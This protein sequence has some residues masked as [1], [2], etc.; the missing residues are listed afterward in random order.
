MQNRNPTPF[1]AEGWYAVALTNSIRK[2]CRPLKISISGYNFA[3]WRSDAG[4]VVVNE[5]YCP[6]MGVAL[7]SGTIENDLIVCPYHGFAFD[8]T[9][10]CK[11]VPPNNPNDHLSRNCRLKLLSVREEYGLVWVYLSSSGTNSVR[12]TV[13]QTP[14]NTAD[15]NINQISDTIPFPSF[16]EFN[17][18]AFQCVSGQLTYPVEHSLV[19]ANSCDFAHIQ[20]V[21]PDF[22]DPSTPEVEKFEIENATSY[23]AS[24]EIVF[25]RAKVSGLLR[26]LL[27]NLGEDTVR[28]RLSFAM[29]ATNTVA[30]QT[31]SLSLI[32][33]VSHLP[34]SPFETLTSFTIA[35]NFARFANPLMDF[36]TIAYAKTVVAQDRKILS[37]I[38]PAGADLEYVH[39]VAVPADRLIAEFRR[40]R[41]RFKNQ[42]RH[43]FLQLDR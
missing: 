26:L 36:I 10:N 30:L 3:I 24:S 4:E 17:D 37:S 9:G 19:A 27:D 14:A 13:P 23:S 32:A 8:S 34:I 31:G 40:C 22:A 25:K 35:R 15:S 18:A 2:N 43:A 38:G 11:K 5:D 39:K 20:R 41:A 33:F 42:G 16:S 6:H 1:I 29:P 21:H 28:V 7:S 12:N